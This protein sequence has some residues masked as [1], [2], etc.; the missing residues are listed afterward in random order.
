MVSGHNA[1]STERQEREAES[2]GQ[3]GTC[4]RDV[5]GQVWYWN[6]NY[7]ANKEST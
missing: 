4:Y 5:D 7:N 6:V 2:S 3:E 1:G